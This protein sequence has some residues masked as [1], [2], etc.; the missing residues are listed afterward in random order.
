MEE[1][2]CAFCGRLDNLKGYRGWYI[3]AECAE[4]IA[5]RSGLAD[6]LERTEENL[7]TTEKTL[8]LEKECNKTRGKS[9]ASGSFIGILA[10]AAILVSAKPLVEEYFLP[11]AAVIGAVWI[12]SLI[13]V[14]AGSVF[15]YL[16]FLGGKKKNNEDDSRANEQ[17]TGGRYEN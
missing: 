9:L 11:G 1:K 17:Q 14:A 6:E 12:I 15:F 4:E 16:N 8:L 3:C 5:R 2:Q 10:M 13:T 7:S